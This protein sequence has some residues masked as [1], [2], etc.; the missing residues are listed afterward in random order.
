MSY[1]PLI[2]PRYPLVVRCRDGQAGTGRN[3]RIRSRWSISYATTHPETSS[4]H[5]A[6]QRVVKITFTLPNLTFQL[7]TTYIPFNASAF[8]P[9]FLSPVLAICTRRHRRSRVPLSCFVVSVLRIGG[10]H[11][12]GVDSSRLAWFSRDR[13][14]RSRSEPQSSSHE[15]LRKGKRGSGQSAVR[16]GRAGRAAGRLAGVSRTS[17]RPAWVPLGLAFWL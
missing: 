6:T 8:R 4:R 10:V 3:L 1:R 11:S 13:F 2:G 9:S 15:D 17:S 16:A 7:L 5:D 12:C 14:I